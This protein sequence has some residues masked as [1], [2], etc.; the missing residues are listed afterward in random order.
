MKDEQIDLFEDKNLKL[1]N[2]DDEMKSSFL[3]YAMSVIVCRA[4]PDVRDGLKPV[5]RR[6]L[7]AMYDANYVAGK[8]YKKCAR[9]VGDVLGRYHPHGDTAV[10]DSLVRMAQDFSMRYELIDGQGNY[11]SVDGDSAAAMRYT[12][13]RMSKISM[14]LLAD[15][16]KNT[17]DFVPNFDESLTEPS[18]LP[19][20]LPNLLLNGSSGI[21]VG[22]ATNI[23]PHHLGELVDGICALIDN[24]DLEILDLLEYIKG[25]D[26]PTG[27][28][29]C[30]THGIKQ[31]YLTGRGSITIRAKVKF[32]ESKKK[33]KQSI[34]VEELPYQVNKAS[35]IMKIAEL[36]QEKKL[37]G[38]ADLRDE[39]D[40][41]GMRIY[42]ELKKD[43]QG[44]VVLNQLYK[45]TQ[46][47]NYFGINTVA[48]VNG[49]PK[50]LNLKDILTHYIAHRKVVII[51][52]TQFDLKKAQDR[53]HILEGLRIA[54]QNIDAVIALIKQSKDVETARLGLIEKFAL[55]EKQAIAILEM[56]L[57]RLTN[58]ERNKLE[59]E[60]Q[61]L[62]NLIKDLEDILSN[63]PRIYQIIKDEQLEIK[64][65]YN[66]KRRT[67]IGCSVETLDLEDMIA[68][69]K[70]AVLISKKGFIKRLSLTNFRSQMRGGRGVNSMNIRDE[71]LVDQLLIASN[72]E[73]LLCFTTKGRVFRIKV[74]QIPEASRQSK[75]I[76]V[77]HF[78][79]LED[80]E[81]IT[82]AI[83]LKN[84][85]ETDCLFMTTQKG[86]VKKT[87]I[88]AFVNLKNRSIIAIN[89]DEGDKLKWVRRTN[90]N[91]DIILITRLGMAIRF[92]E[93]EIR[94]LGRGTR[95]VKGINIKD[96][97]SLISMDVIDP[98][99]SNLCLLLLTEQGFGKTIEIKAFKRQG[100]GGIGVRSFKF[101]KKIDNDKIADAIITAKDHELMIITE[102]GTMC[103]QKIASISTQSRT[104]QGVK[105]VKLDKN[106]TVI[107][108]EKVFEEEIVEE[109]IE[110][111]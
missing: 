49:V 111:K 17:V 56:R 98:N 77:S 41:K 35:L 34:I 1:I 69:E 12:E 39:S 90:G 88:N 10:Y 8:P 86:I 15:I 73:H 76:S 109:L 30:G 25:P 59:D 26:F 7:Y 66:D 52:R 95:G 37:V 54:L 107:A 74:Y 99:E 92:N 6:I 24:P 43:A 89:L 84:L 31:A 63:E 83:S 81:E 4:L 105:V 87:Q 75:G 58:L 19:S 78:F 47:Q 80:N 85:N 82:S 9:I 96:N 110:E 3:A 13:A 27:G 61:N 5:H 32:E 48:L 40:R 93:T 97:D 67:E 57:Q 79:D 50:T 106:D 60:Y 20:R 51:R 33:G 72:L 62:M 11:G 36:V 42:I 38:I 68:D 29:I 16:E 23:P 46:L 102:Q 100:R 55:S 14:E 21:A 70:M 45:H 101:R 53:V 103:R 18:V 64:A 91:K 104:A 108:I 44:E 2:I 65:K 22:M 71:D 28:I 94:I